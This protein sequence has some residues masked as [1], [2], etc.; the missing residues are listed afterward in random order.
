METIIL[1]FT[2][3]QDLSKFRKVVK[4]RVIETNV[5]ELTLTCQCTPEELAVARKYHEARVIQH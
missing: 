5:K 1:Q 3:P 2:T 4:D